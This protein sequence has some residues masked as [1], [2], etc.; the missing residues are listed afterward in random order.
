MWG[1]WDKPCHHDGIN[2]QPNPL[3]LELEAEKKKEIE[4]LL[5]DKEESALAGMVESFK[6]K[7][8]R[9]ISQPARTLMRDNME[10]V[11][12]EFQVESIEDETVVED[13]MKALN[14]PSSKSPASSVAVAAGA[15]E[16]SESCGRGSVSPKQQQEAAEKPPSE[17]AEMQDGATTTV[18]AKS[19]FPAWMYCIFGVLGASLVALVGMYMYN[20]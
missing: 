19:E 4:A 16:D 11:E 2:Q 12:I 20:K 3:R 8:P 5:H 7:S 15:S 17:R 10:T 14:S 6:V 1:F 13:R 9:H 18:Q